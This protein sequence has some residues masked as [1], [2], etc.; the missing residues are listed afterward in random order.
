MEKALITIGEK[1][2]KEIYEE[3]K[4]EEIKCHFCNTKYVFTKEQ[5]GELL[6][7]IK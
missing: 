1:D 7:K 6:T 4:D 5:I 3:R 2:L